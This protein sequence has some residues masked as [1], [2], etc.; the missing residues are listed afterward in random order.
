MGFV[1]LFEYIIIV[2]III[3]NTHNLFISHSWSYS[4]QYEGLVKLL[5]DRPYFGYENYSVPKND[6]IHDAGSDRELQEA[7]KTKMQLC[8]VVLIL[9]GVYATYSKW[10][11]IEIDLA[12]DG[13][14]I[15]KPII[16]I[17]YWGSQKTSVK[18][19]ESADRIVKWQ[20]VSVVNAIR[21][22]SK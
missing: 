17:E 7:I 8:G 14:L 20:A 16:A 13:F 2:G 19:K 5:N 6:P 18:V 15:P 4:N 22:L 1:I 21:E 12:K 11:D 10:I 9:A 3:M